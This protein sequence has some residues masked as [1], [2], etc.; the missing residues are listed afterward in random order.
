MD[1]NTDPL[2]HLEETWKK[3]HPKLLSRAR[4]GGR[5]LEDAQDLV[6]DVFAETLSKLGA[7]GTI[8]NPAAWINTLLGRRIID[9]WRRSKAGAEKGLQTMEGSLL[10]EVA[11]SLGL[12]PLD[13]FVAASL[14]DAL[15]DAV[16]A[17]PEDQRQ[18]IL[19]QVYQGKSFRS[20]EKRMGI[21]AE[22]LAS[23]KRKG[24]ETLKKVLR[25]WI[26]D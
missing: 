12:D 23:R 19:W 15:R 3:E 8:V 21:P 9:A 13:D 1:E 26:E 2:R 24:L 18:I 20:L 17:L 5:S 7:L 25:A 10:A 22:T 4:R 6:G 11:P 14:S 16:E